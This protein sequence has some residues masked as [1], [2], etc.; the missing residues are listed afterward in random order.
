KPLICL[1]EA[2]V[3]LICP[4]PVSEPAAASRFEVHPGGA[5]ANVAVAARRAGAPA[6]LASACGDDG[7]GRYLRR[8]LAEAG[9]DLRFY[10][11][12]EGVPTPFAFACLDPDLEPSFEIH[13]AGIDDA[14]ASLAG[15]EEEVAAG[16]AAVVFGSNT[17][18]D[19]RSRAVTAAIVAAAG[20]RGV[21]VLFDPNLRPG[22]WRTI[23]DCRERCLEVA[24]DAAVLR[25]NLDEARLLAGADDLDAAAAA[26]ALL[27]LGPGLAVV[28]AGPGLAVARGACA[29]EARPPRVAVVSPLGAGDAFMGA[30]A[31]GLADVGFDLSR[32]GG[33]LATAAAA[34]ARTCTHLEAFP[35]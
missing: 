13:G 18:V 23:D 5:L 15:R 20:G 25:C 9:V 11:E 32:A 7:R 29:A 2:L 8:R 17:L 4:D 12:L 27:E 16:A 19:E 34:G 33:A 22:R 10:G 24:A 14:I 1:G 30:L 3:D 31:A 28:T 6:A 26:A 21:P 35:S